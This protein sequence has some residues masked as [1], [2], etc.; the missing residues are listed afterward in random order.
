MDNKPIVTL[1]DYQEWQEHPVTKALKTVLEGWREQL[2]DQLEEGIILRG[3]HY[4][5][6]L[7]SA[8][9]V[10]NLSVIKQIQSLDYE[11][12]VSFLEDL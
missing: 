8:Q 12:M 4:E 5:N 10:G 1:R 7:T 6:E 11:G 9:M 2:R 3:G